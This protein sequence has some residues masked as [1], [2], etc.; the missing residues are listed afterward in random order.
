MNKK[1]I[2]IVILILSKT[3]IYSQP[4]EP[5]NFDNATQFDSSEGVLT[6]GNNDSSFKVNY[7]YDTDIPPIAGNQNKKENK[8][9]K[10]KSFGFSFSKGRNSHFGH[11]ARRFENG[12]KEFL[13]GK[14]EGSY[15]VPQKVRFPKPGKS[16]IIL[17]KL[18]RS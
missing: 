14:T 17:G 13:N 16:I 15:L 4:R 5:Q 18:K 10:K 7:D 3:L 11:T 6:E 2:V 12:I 1:I 8:S 9:K